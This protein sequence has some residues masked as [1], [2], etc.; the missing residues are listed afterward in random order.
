MRVTGWTA[1]SWQSSWPQTASFCHDLLWAPLFCSNH[2]LSIWIAT[3]WRKYIQRY[4]HR[5][6]N[7]ACPVTRTNEALLHKV[8]FL[9]T[10]FLFD[11]CVF[12]NGRGHRQKCYN[13]SPPAV[14]LEILSPF[15][16]ILIFYFFCIHREK[17]LL[18]EC[19]LTVGFSSL[20]AKFRVSDW[21]K[22]HVSKMN[23]IAGF[24]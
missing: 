15:P 17:S 9:Q 18:K 19:N 3:L 14:L 23:I 2:S 24:S 20:L 16:P 5:C 22:M 10:I 6:G 11:P 21:K 1:V 8:S 7:C 13:S 12:A 4:F